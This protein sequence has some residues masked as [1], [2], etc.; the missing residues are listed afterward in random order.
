MWSLELHK[1]WNRWSSQCFHR[2]GISR[3]K[4]CWTCRT[5]WKREWDDQF[6]V[7]SVGLQMLVK[8]SYLVT[9]I[10]MKS[11]R[12]PQFSIQ[13]WYNKHLC[14]VNWMFILS[15]AMEIIDRIHKH[16][17][18]DCQLRMNNKMQSIPRSYIVGRQCSLMIE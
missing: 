8:L 14:C 15:V 3:E 13:L 2:R 11:W 4:S 16:L 10:Y 5:T 9:E 12:Y 1:L 6:Y 7:F 18:C 17:A